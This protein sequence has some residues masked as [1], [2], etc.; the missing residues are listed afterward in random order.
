MTMLIFFDY[1]FYNYYLFFQ[2][3][4]DLCEKQKIPILR[5]GDLFDSI[6]CLSLLQSWN[7]TAIIILIAIILKVP[8]YVQNFHYISIAVLFLLYGYN[9]LRYQRKNKYKN[10]IHKFKG[11]GILITILYSVFSLFFAILMFCSLKGF[12]NNF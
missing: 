3:Q 1:I 4:D 10:I 12:S 6:F 8:Q 2:W 9:Y 5:K 7:I 11:K